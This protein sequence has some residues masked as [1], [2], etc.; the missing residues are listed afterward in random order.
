MKAV[1]AAL[2]LFTFFQSMSFYGLT[3]LQNQKFCE[4]LAL[5]VFNHAKSN[6]GHEE[7][8]EGGSASTSSQKCLLL[9]FVFI[10]DNIH[11]KKPLRGLFR[12]I[13][14][15]AVTRVEQLVELAL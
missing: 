1:E 14:N 7:G 9:I 5:S 15:C 4:L 13:N 3:G 2:Y 10:S 12:R 11:L 8:Q 6:E